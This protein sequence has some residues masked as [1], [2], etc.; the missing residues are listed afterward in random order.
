MPFN[1]IFVF[2]TLGAALVLFVG[3]WV[4]YDVVALLALLAVTVVGI[5][6]GNAAF[7][8]FGH[9]AVVTVVAVLVISR[10]LLN[11]GL[12]D[13]L[14]RLLGRVGEN[15]TLQLA[16]LLAVVTICSAFMNNVGAL[17]LVMPVAIRVARR[18]RRSPGLYLMP[19][20]FASLLGGMTTLI[21]TPPNV[22]IATFRADVN[23][24]PFGIFDFA[25]VGVGIA[26]VGLVYIGLVGWRLV[27]QRSSPATTDIFHIE[28]YST[29]VQVRADSRLIGKSLFDLKGMIDADVVV[30]TLIRGD[31]RIPAPSSYEILIA[32]DI[33]IVEAGSSDDLQELL[34]VAKLDLLHSKKIKRDA[35][36]DDNIVVTEAVVTS[37]SLM[38]G[39]TVISLNLRWR[40]GVNLLAVARQGE[41]LSDRLSAI[42]FRAGDILLLQG[43]QQALRRALTNLGCL[44][45]ADRDLQIGKPRRLLFSLGLFGVALTAATLGFLPIQTALV[46]AGLGMVLTRILSLR[47]AYD[48]VDWPI[49]VLLGAMI[50][51]GEALEITGGAQRIA[52]GLY[53]LSGQF[54]PLITLIILLLGSMFLSDLI[55]NAAA[56]VLLAPIA[57]GLAQALG[58]NPDPFLMAVGIGAS[59]AFLTPIGHQSNTLV[60]GPGGYRFGDYWRMGLPLE[61]LILVVGIPLLLWFWPLGI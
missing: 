52:E 27:P 46:M 2:A 53:L 22:I 41:R 28:D 24:Q 44:P 33:L 37:D 36:G 55:N 30:L 8:G 7:M 34:D 4:R 21:G 45:L 6:P 35:L 47:E 17:A 1:E 9:P 32:D 39:H 16:A 19:L 18:S 20:A 25:P 54:S 42:R 60:M 40:H 11:A 14:A 10:G 31:R 38:V 57:M 61:I 15:F 23:G 3:G 50:P 26:L 29:E 12:V 43:P 49:I 13:S 51:V 5:V 48:A 56:A 58:A 59:C